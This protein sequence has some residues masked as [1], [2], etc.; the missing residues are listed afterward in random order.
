[1]AEYLGPRAKMERLFLLY[2][3]GRCCENL[4]SARS[5]A[6]YKSGPGNNM[7]VVVTNY[8]TTFHKPFISTSPVLRDKMLLKKKN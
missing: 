4:Q 7:L 1:M 8:C 3:A 6:K 2:L 5:P